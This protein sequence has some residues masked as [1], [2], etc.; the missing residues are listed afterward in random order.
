VGGLEDGIDDPELHT[1]FSEF[2]FVTRALRY[3][4]LP[5][6]VLP[7]SGS[8]FFPSWIPDLHQRILVF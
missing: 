4:A 2:G 3:S 6:V 7:I 8:E 5:I 1:Y